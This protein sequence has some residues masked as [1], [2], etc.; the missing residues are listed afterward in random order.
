M[1]I[2]GD[3]T[4]G[5]AIFGAMGVTVVGDCCMGD[6]FRSSYTPVRLGDVISRGDRNKSRTPLSLGDLGEGLGVL[7]SCRTPVILGLDTRFGV[8]S[9]SRIPVKLGDFELKGETIIEPGPSGVG[10]SSEYRAAM[11]DFLGV[12]TLISSPDKFPS[13]VTERCFT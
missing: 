7:I 6:A 12:Y 8:F 10:G 13:L 3:F 4:P 5:E 9:S 2:L 11:G 1:T